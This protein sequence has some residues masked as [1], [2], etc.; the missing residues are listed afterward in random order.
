[1]FLL[2]SLGTLIVVVCSMKMFRCGFCDAPRQYLVVTFT[3]LFFKYDYPGADETF[4]INYFFMS[5][6][7]GKV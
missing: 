6:L 5:I 3:L 7:F 2:F 4:I 1:M